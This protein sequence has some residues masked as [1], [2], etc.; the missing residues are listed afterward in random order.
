MQKK[1]LDIFMDNP[2]YS[3]IILCYKS[4]D[5]I[6]ERIKQIEKSLKAEKI[7]YEIILVCNYI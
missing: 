1:I 5:Q 4:N 6:I 7:N 2:Q 3:I